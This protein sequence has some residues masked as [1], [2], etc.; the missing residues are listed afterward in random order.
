M[1]LHFHE[2]ICQ[3]RIVVTEQ[4]AMAYKGMAKNRIGDEQVVIDV[5]IVD[6]ILGLLIVIGFRIA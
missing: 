6:L 2:C 4:I 5:F 1:L 3:S